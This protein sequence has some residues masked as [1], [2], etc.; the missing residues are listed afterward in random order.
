MYWRTRLARTLRAPATP[1]LLDTLTEHER[2]VLALVAWGVA[3]KEIAQ[4]LNIQ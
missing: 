3:N 1:R 4:R 2:K